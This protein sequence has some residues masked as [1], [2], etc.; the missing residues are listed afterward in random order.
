MQSATQIVHDEDK[1]LRERSK[2]RSEKRCSCL[3]SQ[4]RFLLPLINA[5][6][7]RYPD[8]RV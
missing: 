1:D 3:P 7:T 6:P 4:T 2:E 5:F 8:V